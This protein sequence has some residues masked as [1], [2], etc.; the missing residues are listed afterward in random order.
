M[1]FDP[2]VGAVAKTCFCSEG[3]PL[4]IAIAALSAR[5]L[6]NVEEDHQLTAVAKWFE[7]ALSIWM[8]CGLKQL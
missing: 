1:D 5:F 3:A 8:A 6:V 2:G 7:D 4:R